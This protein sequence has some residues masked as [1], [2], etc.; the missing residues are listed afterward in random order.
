MIDVPYELRG[1]IRAE[2]VKLF[3]TLMRFG[4]REAVRVLASYLDDN[5]Y[6]Y[7]PGCDYGSAPISEDAAAYLAQLLRERPELPGTRSAPQ[8]L[9][10]WWETNK[11]AYESST[12]TTPK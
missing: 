9:R 10:K 8:N 5:R 1:E 2:Q 7:E 11:A 6:I 4:T 12:P 3:G